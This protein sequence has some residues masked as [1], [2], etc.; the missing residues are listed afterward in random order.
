MNNCVFHVTSFAGLF[1]RQSVQFS[2]VTQS[3][4]SEAH[5]AS[6]P[7]ATIQLIVKR[8]RGKIDKMEIVLYGILRREF[9]AIS[10]SVK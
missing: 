7:S 5:Q 9:L 1:N 4:W 2:S 10:Y 3:P 8:Y 6:W